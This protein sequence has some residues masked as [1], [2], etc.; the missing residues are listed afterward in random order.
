MGLLEVQ[1]VNRKLSLHF[2]LLLHFNK[3]KVYAEEVQ[4]DK[5]LRSQSDAKL[6]PHAWPH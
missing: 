5:I 4:K 6:C 3:P 2:P 1:K